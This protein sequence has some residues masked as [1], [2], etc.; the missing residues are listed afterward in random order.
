MHRN[1]CVLFGNLEKMRSSSI[2]MEGHAECLDALSL[3]DVSRYKLPAKDSQALLY[4]SYH[5]PFGLGSGYRGRINYSVDNQQPPNTVKTRMK[6]YCGYEKSVIS[7]AF[8]G[9]ENVKRNMER[10]G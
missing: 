4:Y 5:K 10:N 6:N 3:L 9:H 1:E 2:G 8:I 7:S